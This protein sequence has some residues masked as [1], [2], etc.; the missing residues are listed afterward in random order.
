MT[1]N[2][3]HYIS[4]LHFDYFNGKKSDRYLH[5]ET[6]FI[7]ELKVSLKDSLLLMAGD[8]YD[9]I[10]KTLK[11]IKKIENLK[12]KGFFVLGNHDYWNTGIYNIEK[13]IEIVTQ[14][15]LNNKYFKFLKSG[16]KYEIDGIVF[17]GDTG[18]SSFYS[19]KEEL[20]KPNIVLPEHNK[21]KNFSIIKVIEIHND[22]VLFAK[23]TIKENEKVIVLTHFPMFNSIDYFSNNSFSELW[24]KS[25]VDLKGDNFWNI[26]GHTHE[27]VKLDNYVTNQIGSNNHQA[28]NIIDAYSET[29]HYVV[30]N[31]VR[32][33]T[34]DIVYSDEHLLNSFYDLSISSVKD[35]SQVQKIK[36]RGY[37]RTSSNIGVMNS[38]T[39][40]IDAF[41]DRA[42]RNI[43]LQSN[44]TY[45][46]FSSSSTS[47]YVIYRALNHSIDVLK[48]GLNNNIREYI[49]SIVIVGYAWN[50]MTHL[51]EYMRPIDDIDVIR[52]YLYI[53]TIQKHNLNVKD[54]YKIQRH[55]KNR[56]KIN[57][58][59]IYIPVINDKYNIEREDV[60][61]L[62]NSLINEIVLIN[63]KH[64]VEF[65]FY[66]NPKN[67]TIVST[68]EKKL[69]HNE[70]Q[71]IKYKYLRSKGFSRDE[72]TNM[73]NW[74]YERIE[75]HLKD[76]I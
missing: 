18:W 57:D 30:E 58:I 61:N 4:D 32:T 71:R 42:K 25:L 75:K 33:T 35:I 34:K 50:N 13:I 60:E 38:A 17:I 14:E 68:D 9:D 21:I 28:I 46:G 3:V 74:T 55:K 6:H 12:I 41:I 59:D 76:I 56:I 1:I 65:H 16:I 22:W 8:F 47:S 7:Q 66:D 23:K 54:V 36:K 49:T 73:K 70:I 53:K 24:F 62:N 37:I 2:K 45:I 43:E 10:L 72:A 15:T 40:D 5:R 27:K 11:F 26:Y 51:L 52:M 39:N 29:I 67:I 48:K 63:Q 64:V 19:G 69:K 20:K 44:K 31:L